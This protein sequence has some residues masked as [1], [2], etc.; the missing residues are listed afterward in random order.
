MQGI[1]PGVGCGLA[2]CMAKRHEKIREKRK[3]EEIE[4]NAK[5][6][7][8]WNKIDTENKAHWGSVQI[9]L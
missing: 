9:F 8:K 4:K 5:T 3:Q 2:V 7:N 1:L 6:N